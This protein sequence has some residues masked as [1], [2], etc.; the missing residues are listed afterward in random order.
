[1]L[2]P[3]GHLQITPR[4][5]LLRLLMF[6]CEDTKIPASRHT[7]NA[8][9]PKRSYILSCVYPRWLRVGG[10]YCA[11]RTPLCR[12]TPEGS[13]AMLDE[14]VSLLT[15][16]QLNDLQLSQRNVRSGS[17]SIACDVPKVHS[18]PRRGSSHAALPEQVSLQTS[19]RIYS[20]IL[21]HY[22]NVCFYFQHL[23]YAPD[24]MRATLKLRQLIAPR[25]KVASTTS[26]KPQNNSAIPGGC[27][28][29]G[30][31]CL[32]FP[33]CPVGLLDCWHACELSLL[34]PP[35]YDKLTTSTRT[36]QHQEQ[37]VNKLDHF[38]GPLLSL[39][40]PR[41][42]RS[43]TLARGLREGLRRRPILV[44]IGEQIT[45]THRRTNYE[46]TK[47]NKLLQAT[48][49]CKLGTDPLP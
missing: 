15:H 40:A 25:S 31:P 33:R 18:A 32:Q 44:V 28:G 1:M 43:E 11:A 45:K 21:R 17:V 23:C 27:L 14:P 19:Q 6:P 48:N 35:L 5:N 46:I 24:V 20:S 26:A 38:Q 3:C 49:Y 30:D 39:V 37:Y 8:A 9:R 34:N 13:S 7:C 12:C 16:V 10:R 42:A 22:V 41:S 29:P 4:N 47:Q 36:Q 2:A